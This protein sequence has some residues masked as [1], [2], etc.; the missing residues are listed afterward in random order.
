MPSTHLFNHSFIGT[1]LMKCK[2]CQR[3]FHI[4]RPWQKFCSQAHRDAFH[5]EE[6]RDVRALRDRI[7]ALEKELE[8]K[9]TTNG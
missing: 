8:N 7:A 3:E 5:L 9:G 2:F 6:R 1:S 4:K